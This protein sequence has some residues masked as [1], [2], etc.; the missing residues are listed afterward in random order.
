M[1]TIPMDLCQR[2]LKAY[3]RGDATREEGSRRFEV[4]LGFVKNLIQQRRH[5]GD[6]GSRHHRSGRKPLVLASHRRDLRALLPKQADLTL[7]ESRRESP[8]HA[9][10]AVRIRMEQREGNHGQRGDAE[11]HLLIAPASTGDGA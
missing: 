10:G 6:I 4:S 5:T 2:I 3:D 1:A 8:S 7:A 9:D 11:H